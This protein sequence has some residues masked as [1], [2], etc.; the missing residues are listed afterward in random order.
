MQRL[1]TRRPVFWLAAALLLGIAWWSRQHEFFWDTISQASLRSTWFYD[2]RFA[3]FFLPVELDS[4]HPPLFNWYLAAGWLA[5]GRT[6]PVSHLLMAPFLLVIAWQWQRLFDFLRKQ[7]PALPPWLALLPLLDTTLLSQ[8]SLVSADLAMLACTLTALNAILRKQDG[9]LFAALV[10]L[11]LLNLRGLPAAAALGLCWLIL[12]LS[13]NGARRLSPRDLWPWAAAAAVWLM[14]FGAHHAHTG[15]WFS[16]PNPR[17][18]EHRHFSGPGGLAWNAGITGWRLL[19]YGRLGYWLVLAAL[20]ARRGMGRWLGHP[21]PL[22]VLCFLGV[23]ALA[24]WPVSNP[25][26]H[27][28]F[29]PVLLVLPLWVATESWCAGGR[30]RKWGLPLVAALLLSGHFWVY[31]RGIA[32]GWD[33]TTAHWPWYGLR[34]DMLHFIEAEG[35]D[36]QQVGTRFPNAGPFDKLDLS[37]RQ[38]GLP[39]LD[40]QRH[41]YVFYSNIMNDFSDAELA[42]LD[43][44]PVRHR[45]ER[46]GICVILFENAN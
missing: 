33:G 5:L 18:T 46:G 22:F 38:E 42:R 24:M 37:G 30:F 17:W 43:S 2:Q 15:W 31:P 1:L 19:D 28:Y 20:V 41:R 27:R 10:P 34:R 32:Q 35:I 3:T 6:L 40:W 39:R 9:W 13:A 36:W 16:T 25:I 21:L 14:W 29:L 45:L 8:A 11:G 44:L 7:N 26:T 12:R 4:G 23:H